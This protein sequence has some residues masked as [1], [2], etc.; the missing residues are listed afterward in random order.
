M[1]GRDFETQSHKVFSMFYDPLPDSD[2]RKKRIREFAANLRMGINKGRFIK[3][4]KPYPERYRKLDVT[5]LY[6]FEIGSD[7]V[8]YTLRTTDDRRI[9][10]FL[11][12][13]THSDYDL[14]FHNRKTT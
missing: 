7:R 9:W 8:I 10:Q 12:Y 2:E 5:N 1:S 14:L 6:V 3:Q 13:L 4:D 11:D